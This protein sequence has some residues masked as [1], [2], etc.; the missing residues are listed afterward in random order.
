MTAG[1]KGIGRLIVTMPPRHG[2]SLTVS[3][4]FPA[5]LLGRYSKLRVALV[6]YSSDISADF[7]R[8][9][10][11]LLENEL[12]Y[13]RIFPDTKVHPSSGAVERWSLAGGSLDDPSFVAVG[14]GGA[15][16]GR[17]FQLIIVDDPVKNRAEAESF[18]YRRRVKDF[19]KGTLR[20][21]LEPGG[22]IVVI[23]TRWH[24]DDLPGYLLNAA[25][26]GEGEEWDILNLPAIAIKDDTIG[27]RLDAPLWPERFGKQALKR[28]RLA[29]GHYEWE[30]QYQ[31][32][33]RPPE[34][35]H[36]QREWFE[37]ID[38]APE[39]LRWVRY[40]D[41]AISTKESASFTASCRIALDDD[42][43]VYITDMVRG[44]WEWHQ[45]RKIMS[46]TMLAEKG[47]NVVHGIE[48]ALHGAVALQDLRADKNLLSIPLQGIGVHK[49]KLTRAL[50]WIARAEAGKI[51]LVRGNWI[52]DFLDEATNFTGG[53]DLHDD[54]IDS[55]S[56]GY[57]MLGKNT[58]AEY[59]RT[60]Y[61]DETN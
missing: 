23:A 39:N 8:A 44:H 58:F 17:G 2:K 14:I 12:A 5:F 28:A 36:I 55:V 9:N 30:A 54:Q 59:L 24:L 38:K 56:G 43:S 18:A 6:S 53:K 21:R 13:R 34:G 50:P 41:L 20:S 10:R 22:A 49:D 7:S 57:S 4:R 25:K 35:T 47:M 29:L 1:K 60:T 3:K 31:G 42:G 51:K 27:R 48:S 37:I 16:T 15:L 32:N 33:P 11:H 52:G 19:Y 46:Q 45:Q 40:W 26:E 61:S